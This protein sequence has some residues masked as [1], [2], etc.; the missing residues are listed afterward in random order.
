MVTV[1]TQPRGSEATI[2]KIKHLADRGQRPI[3]RGWFHLVATFVMAI[4]GTVLTTFTWSHNPWTEGLAVTV[5][6]LAVILLFG[7]SALYHRGPWRTQAGVRWWRRADHSTIAVFIAATY[8]PLCTIV[9][10]PK[11]ALIMLVVAWTGALAQVALS[12]LWI[13]HPRWIDVVAYLVLGWL[14]IPLAP[15]LWAGA[16]PAV[17]WLLV[18]GGIVY[19][20]GALMYGLKWPGRQAKIIGYHEYF[21]ASTIVAAIVH[22]V[23]IWMVVVTG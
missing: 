8:T 20:L 11:T 19:S 4:A 21:H 10:P 15:Q 22:M 23:A 14:I 16:G 17:V 7:V 6:A 5:Y 3:T 12:L 2:V 13:A 9:L 18:A 1:S